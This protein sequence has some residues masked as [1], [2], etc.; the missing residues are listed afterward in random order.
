MDLATS[1]N[2]AITEMLELATYSPSELLVSSQ[3]PAQLS[4]CRAV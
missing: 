2:P 4:S 3:G 1:W